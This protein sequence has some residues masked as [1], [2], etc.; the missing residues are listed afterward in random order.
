[1]HN[2]FCRILKVLLLAV[3]GIPTMLCAQRQV[4]NYPNGMPHYV[5][6]KF[7]ERKEAHI[8]GWDSEG[9][10][11]I[12]TW[13]DMPG[14][15]FCLRENLTVTGKENQVLLKYDPENNVL[16]TFHQDG[17]LKS[18]QTLDLKDSIWTVTDYFQSGKAMEKK[19]SKVRGAILS[20]IHI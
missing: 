10:K 17:A 7:P 2:L 13:C 12:D 6:D 9:Q 3:T 16:E 14:G 8:A 4:L 20:L 5:I 18:R 19:V 15:E 11:M 1:M